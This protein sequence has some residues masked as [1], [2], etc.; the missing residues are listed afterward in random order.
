MVSVAYFFGCVS[1]AIETVGV[2]A[3]NFAGYFSC[4]V[5][6]GFGN[7]AFR[8]RELQNRFSLMQLLHDIDPEW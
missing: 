2:G 4:G 1:C 7:H 6:N 5:A 3:A 8:H